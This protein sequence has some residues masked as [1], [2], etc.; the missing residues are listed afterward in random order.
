MCG[1]C[2]AQHK[3]KQHDVV[4]LEDRLQEDFQALLAIFDGSKEARKALDEHA[5]ACDA[6]V[7]AINKEKDQQVRTVERECD[8]LCRRINTV[9]TEVVRQIQ[10]AA[11]EKIVA[12]NRH[13]A[14][15]QRSADALVTNVGATIRAGVESVD[16]GTKRRY[17]TELQRI[18][19][20]IKSKPVK[21]GEVTIRV[22]DGY[23][24]A[25]AAINGAIS[26]IETKLRGK[27]VT[28]VSGAATYVC[29][30]AF[31]LL[32]TRQVLRTRYMNSARPH[33]I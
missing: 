3:R 30:F 12:V 26:G 32:T 6:T 4:G 2:E 11:E 13:D 18:N 29:T 5:S 16:P 14:R 1:A 7:Q 8:E 15:V 20:I 24:T 17:E 31:Q 9:K 19:E 27:Y 22:D 28:A 25:M 10:I 21:V 23:K 33:N